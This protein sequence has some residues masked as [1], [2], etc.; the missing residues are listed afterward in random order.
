VKNGIISAFR[1]ATLP[2]RSG[3]EG[4]GVCQLLRTRCPFGQWRKATVELLPP[5]GLIYLA[6]G[7]KHGVRLLESLGGEIV[8]RHMR[9]VWYRHYQF[10]TGLCATFVDLKIKPNDELRALAARVR[11]ADLDAVDTCCSDFH[12]EAPSFGWIR[13]ESQKSA[14][15]RK[16]PGPLSLW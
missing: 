4:S 14:A 10:L 2:Q 6:A 1:R 9:V 13:S 7:A 5:H 11:I 15:I 12:A 3:N 16:V 8:E